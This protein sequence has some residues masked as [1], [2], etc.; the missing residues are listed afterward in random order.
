MKSEASEYKVDRTGWPEGP[1]DREPDRIEWKTQAGL[2]GL[3]VRPRHGGWCGY[4]AVPPEHPEHGKSYGAIENEIDVHGGLTYA[5]ACAGVVCH[6]PAP[7]EP[8]NVWWFG[9]DCVHHN[10]FAPGH[11]RSENFMRTLIEGFPSRARGE[12][13]DEA[14]V[15]AEVE[16]LAV[17]LAARTSLSEGNGHG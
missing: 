3:M 17:Q 14:Y 9:F 6:V 11:A 10:D 8:D 13:R 12:Y 5:E 7:G 4:V 15:R 1:W 2:V 16:R